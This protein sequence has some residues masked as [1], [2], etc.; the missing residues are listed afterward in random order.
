ND[1]SGFDDEKPAHTVPIAPVEMAIF[2]VTN[3]EYRLFMQA[4]GYE[5]E[6]WWQTEAA[7]AWLRGDGSNEGEK[8]NIRDTYQLVQDRSDDAIRQAQATPEQ[9]EAW[10][11]L[12]SWSTD[13]LENK[14]AEW[15]PAGQL[16]RQ[17]GYWDDSRFNHPSQPVVG[18]T[19]FEARAYCAWLSAQT[20]DLYRL[21]TEVEWEAAAGGMAG[22]PYAWGDTYDAANCNTFETHIRATTPVGVFPAGNT[23]EGIADLSGNVWEWTSTIW[24]SDLQTPEFPYPYRTDDGRE[25]DQNGDVRR[26]VRG[27]SWL[28]NLRHARVS[29]R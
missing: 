17:P 25:D 15:F 24:G 11:D 16:Y 1:D 29:F 19:W 8:Q 14:L 22:R 12:K 18:I 21:P 2:A 20:G 23:P 26:V 5:D 10:L 4:G 7:R 28:N 27:G 13:T 3:A 6:Q 9:I